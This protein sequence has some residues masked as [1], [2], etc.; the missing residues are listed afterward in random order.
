MRTVLCFFMGLI[1]W[2]QETFA[3][4]NADMSS[5][6]SPVSIRSSVDQL[7]DEAYDLF[8]QSP[9]SAR[10]LAEKALLLSEKI[11]YSAGAGRSF[12]NM[13]KVYWSQSY[14]PIALFYLKKAIIKL[15]KD[16]PLLISD[17]YGTTGR[18][19]AEL[20]N[21]TEAFKYISMADSFAKGDTRTLASVLSE[22][23]YVYLGLHDYEQ[24]V[25]HA[26]R[27]LT[28][29]KQI[30]EYGDM[31]IVYG[32]LG[33]IYGAKKEYKVALPYL[34]TALRMSITTHNRR[35][36]SAVYV[37]Y[38]NIYNQL[39]NYNKAIEYAQMGVALADSIG[40]VDALTGSYHI[41]ISSYKKKNNLKQAMAWQQKFNDTRDSL[42]NFNKTKNIQLIQNV[43]QLNK[44][45]G[46][47][48]S[49]E[50]NNQFI[51]AR[52]H[53]KN[54]LIITLSISLIVL[55]VLLYVTFYY[56]KQK[57]LLS[58][59]L[60]EQHEELL[61]Q[62]QFIEAQAEN[63]QAISTIK[64]KLLAIIGHDLRTPLANLSNII[65]MF[66]LEYLSKE[67]IQQLMKNMNSLVKGAEL[68]LSNLVE[69]AGREIK[70]HTVN[71][72]KVDINLLGAEVEQ[73]FKHALEQKSISFLNQ[74]SP[75][76]LVLAD[77]NHIKVVLRNLV[78]NAIKFTPKG[79]CVNLISEH[80]DIN[81][82]ICVEDNGTGM[83]QEE[84]EKLFQLETHFSQQGTMGEHG[85]GIGLILCKEL[86]ELNGGKLWIDSVPAKGSRFY[87]SL[88]LSKN[89]L[90]I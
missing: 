64:D 51:K 55:V 84:I 16:K 44:K 75:G 14:Y 22:Q 9:D 3:Q 79:G 7:N 57:E 19:Y 56:Y 38:A 45:L 26:K 88:P 68:T 13:G 83:T 43:F 82:V 80:G 72:T 89:A 32:R 27:A 63:L 77:E 81:L 52:I 41:L 87:F 37:E 40:V 54:T 33:G 59:Q 12:F 53:S 47:I 73:T 35:L 78:S 46:E 71:L 61:V 36:R 74:T 60:N 24:A 18:T 58:D 10:I 15:P 76:I 4:V 90:L 17:C 2:H 66:E 69:W 62:K 85:T 28:F 50:R 23:A 5:L 11:N 42:E 25:R 1:L 6:K 31:A 86:I 65:Q 8:L 49:I 34:D 21:Y 48:D 20:K 29:D 67:E 30:K 70:G 39:N